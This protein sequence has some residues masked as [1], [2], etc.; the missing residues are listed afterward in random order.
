VFVTG[1]FHPAILASNGG[2][3]CVFLGSNSHKTLSL[4]TMLEYEHP[5]EHP[6]FP[7]PADCDRVVQDVQGVLA[8]GDARRTAVMAAVTRR[9]E[10]AGRLLEVLN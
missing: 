3:P 5:R 1:R 2:T 6:A 7:S 10:Q 8:A 4:Q 9:C